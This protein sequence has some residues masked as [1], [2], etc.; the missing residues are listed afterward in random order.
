M[1]GEGAFLPGKVPSRFL[2]EGDSPAFR[3]CPELSGAM[4]PLPLPCRKRGFQKAN[5]NTWLFAFSADSFFYFVRGHPL[6]GKTHTGKLLFGESIPGGGPDGHR[7]GRGHVPGKFFRTPSWA[8]PIFISAPGCEKMP[9]P[10]DGKTH[11]MTDPPS[12]FF[13]GCFFLSK[14]GKSAIARKKI[15]VAVK[16][17]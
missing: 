17:T 1:R 6:M 4:A 7:S 2:G 14:A 12:F 9:T 13:G 10:T 11:F 3:S 5:R 16:K 15:P 8:T